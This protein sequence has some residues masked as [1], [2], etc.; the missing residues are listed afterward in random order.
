[1]IQF[2]CDSCSAIKQ[3]EDTWILG[4]AAEVVG[5]RAA[6]REITILPVWAY[7]RAV[8]PLAVHFCSIQCKDN[9]MAE[10]F[11][12]EAEETDQ[13]TTVVERTIP[14]ESG[15]GVKKVVTRASRTRR[16]KSA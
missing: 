8:H 9:Y 15:P 13:T 2:L 3:P 5:V 6:R 4:I 1:M 7:E 10:L 12:M 14:E 16:R 11:P